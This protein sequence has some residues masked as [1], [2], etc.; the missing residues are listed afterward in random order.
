MSPLIASQNRDD[1]YIID[2]LLSQGAQQRPAAQGLAGLGVTSGW[3]QSKQGHRMVETLR[4]RV[5]SCLR[6]LQAGRCCLSYLSL[7]MCSGIIS[8]NQEP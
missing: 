5:Q 3:P 7:P 6:L 2:D 1:T 4:Q 8:H